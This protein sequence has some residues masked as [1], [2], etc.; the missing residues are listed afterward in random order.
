[1][2]HL[3][4]KEFYSQVSKWVSGKSLKVAEKWCNAIVEVII[5]ECFFKHGCRV[6]LLGNFELIH[7][8]ES[9]QT[10][11]KD[12]KT[13]TYIVPERY[14]VKFIPC[15]SFINDVNGEG[16]TKL[17]RQRVKE[18]KLTKRDIERQL[19]F[20]KE[21]TDEYFEQQAKIREQARQERQKEI[22]AQKDKKKKAIKDFEKKLKERVKANEQKD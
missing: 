16:V 9:T 7:H 19:R 13:Q 18:D 17:Y 3:T 4:P 20:E 21:K 11:H 10:Q 6:P 22:K 12:G 15:D 2:K 8:E 1:M 5:Q 14:S